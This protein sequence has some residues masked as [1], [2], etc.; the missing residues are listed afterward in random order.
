MW[1]V[2]SYTSEKG[3]PSFQNILPAVNVKEIFKD[4]VK[5]EEKLRNEVELAREFM[6]LSNEPRTSG[7]CEA[8]M[9]LDQDLT[10]LCL[11]NVVSHM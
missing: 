7:K 2:N 11:W 3:N 9:L 8:A 10:G 6:Y 5:Q 4:A 1:Q